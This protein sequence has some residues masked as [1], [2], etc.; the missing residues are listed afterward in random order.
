MNMDNQRHDAYESDIEGLVELAVAEELTRARNGELSSVHTV[1]NV[2]VLRFFDG[3]IGFN[4]VLAA[5]KCTHISGGI[6]RAGHSQVISRLNYSRR[7]L[8]DLTKNW[9]ASLEQD[10]I[11]RAQTMYPRRDAATGLSDVVRGC[12][13]FQELPLSIARSYLEVDCDSADQA[14]DMMAKHL[15]DIL[16]HELGS[17]FLTEHADQSR[18]DRLYSHESL[19]HFLVD[20]VVA[21]DIL[22]HH[23]A[24]WSLWQLFVHDAGTA[25]NVL[26]RLRGHSWEQVLK[27]FV[28]RY[29]IND[30]AWNPLDQLLYLVDLRLM[31]YRDEASFAINSVLMLDVLPVSP[32]A[33]EAALLFVEKF[34][35][36]RK[37]PLVE[38]ERWVYAPIKALTGVLAA[39]VDQANLSDDSQIQQLLQE[40][41][42]M[43]PWL[44]SLDEACTLDTTT[45]VGAWKDW[46]TAALSIPSQ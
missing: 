15:G 36:A 16:Y 14:I 26:E 23:P 18:Y 32:S 4:L 2:R 3:D 22:L 9:L 30:Y 20:P 41:L 31:P 45:V 27:E 35:W 19:N 1:E 13:A 38:N 34:F 10:L 6:S 25:D 39:F 28:T 5:D 17:R 46:R 40:A 11:G 12:V 8:R 42:G 29:G 33:F 43:I 24:Y 37:Q 7:G 21:E 44:V